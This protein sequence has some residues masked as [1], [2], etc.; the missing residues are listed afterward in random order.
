MSPSDTFDVTVDVTPTAAGDLVNTAT[1]DPGTNIAEGNEGNNNSSDTVTVLTVPTIAKTFLANPIVAGNTSTLRFTVTNPNA[2]QALNGIAF[3]DTMPTGMTLAA[4]VITPQCGGTVVG[5]AGSDTVSLSGGSIA[6]NGSCTVDVSVTVAIGGR[7]DNSSGSVSSTNGGTGNTAS[8]SL[9]A[10]D[11]QPGKEIVAT[12]EAFTGFVGVREKIA[13]GEMVRY[14]ITA[15]LP[16]GSFTNLQFS[17]NIPNGLQFLDDGTARFAF[18]SDE[19]GITSSSLTC[20]NYTGIAADTTSLPSTD[21]DCLLTGAISDSADADSEFGNGEDVTFSLGDLTNADNDADNEFVVVE[22]N[23]MILNVNSSVMINDGVDND[24]SSATAGQT[25]ANWRTNTAA[26]SVNGSQI[27]TDSNNVSI[28]IAEPAIITLAKSETSGGSY[29]PGTNIQYTFIF[30]N[31]ATGDNAVTAFDIKLTDTLDANL[32]PGAINI[33]STQGTSGVDSCAGG[34]TFTAGSSISSQD[35]TVNVSCLDVGES[36]TVEI[37]AT[38]NAAAS[39]GT[40]VSN[41]GGLSYTSLPGAQGNCGTA[42][43][44]C[45]DL[46]SSGSQTGERNGTGGPGSDSAVLNNYAVTSNTV[47]ITVANANLLP[48]AVDDSTNTLKNTPVTTPNVLS[49]DDQGDAPATITAFDATSAK[50]GTVTDNGDGTF[51][52]DPP[53]GFTGTD[54]F[55]YTI[56]DN[57]GDTH[58]PQ[59]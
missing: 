49:N 29:L 3:S 18:V 45:T 24:P 35:A 37:N 36:V 22:F 55:T 8:A 16:E 59:Q 28:E 50:G 25:H 52:Y 1:V 10:F 26:L 31:N 23:A 47:D 57:N 21:V 5:A 58:R 54:I 27:G 53:A 38:I 7:Y 33:F 42:P 15:Q 34:T 40:T 56:T 32:T 17:D 48:N 12:S 46:G 43:F 2:A 13:I 4:D 19:G 51:D 11:S 30:A 14:R 9:I 44:A 39:G 6:A 41:N 20:V